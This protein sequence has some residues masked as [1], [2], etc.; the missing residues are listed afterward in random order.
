MIDISS[1]A[2]LYNDYLGCLLGILFFFSSSSSHTVFNV[3]IQQSGLELLILKI[4]FS[5]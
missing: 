2:I 4:V 1:I 5:I 3:T